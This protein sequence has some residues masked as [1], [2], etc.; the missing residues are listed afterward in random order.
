MKY[1]NQEVIDEIRDAVA[2]RIMEKHLGR[3]LLEDEYI[4]HK[5]GKPEDNRVG[6]LEIIKRDR[7]II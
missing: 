6:N 5:N 7:T 4:H 1:E 2:I 3:E